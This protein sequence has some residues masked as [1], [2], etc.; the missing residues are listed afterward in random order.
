MSKPLRNVGAVFAASAALLAG[1]SLLATSAEA[2]TDSP[3][4]NTTVP[5]IIT[6][7]GTGVSGFSGNGVAA[8]KAELAA[9]S[10]VAESPAGDL[11]IVDTTNNRIRQVSSPTV[12]NDDL[13]T[14][15]AGKA[16]PGF[17]GDGGQAT[18]AKLDAP[19]AV[20]VDNQGDVFIA[21]TGNNRIREINAAG[22]ITTVAGNGACGSG[23]ALGNSGPAT[24]A[25]LCDPSGI[26]VNSAGDLFISD[27]G[28]DEVREVT[29]GGTITDF[30]GNAEQG[31]AGN[32]GKA[33]KA[34]L[35]GPSGLA[36]DAIGNLFIADSGNNEVR[37]V[38]TKNEINLFAGT[39]AA[40]HSGNGGQAIDA[41]LSDPTG[42]GIDPSGNVYI[43][44][45]GNNE[46]R[47]VSAGGVI[48]IYAGTGKSGKS[49]DSGPATAAKLN[50]P[51]GSIAADGSAVYFAD[52]G[53]NRIQGVFVGPPPTLPESP[54]AVALPIG[55]VALFGGGFLIMRRRKHS[56]PTVA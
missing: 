46:I 7:A 40:G 12:E 49:G 56:T 17:S 31:S 47:Q 14:T 34:E 5:T 42:V 24:S 4:V 39:G 26:A 22:I 9:P 20:A 11:Y 45:T 55:A 8:V 28:H 23:I 36:I 32:G 35:D 51:T 33:K 15:I 1:G 37:V 21:D 53:N 48:S 13:I 41:K 43:S 10:G 2:A 50:G 29:P 16:T 44:D 52:R 18:N 27:T 25:S 54:L 3:A 19:T 30:A 6:V 38:S